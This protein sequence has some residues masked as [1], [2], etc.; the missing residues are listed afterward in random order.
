MDSLPIITRQTLLDSILSQYSVQ[1]GADFAGYRNHCYRVLNVYLQLAQLNHSDVDE[2]EAAV[3]LAFHDIGLWTD[4]TLD[5]LPPSGLEAEQ[6][7]ANCPEL[8]AQQI[9]LMISEHHKLSPYPVNR[10]IELFRQADLVDFSLGLVRHGVSQAFIRKLKAEFPNAGFHRRLLQL[11]LKNLL[12]HPL[13]P[14]PM[15]KW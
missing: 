1:L 14:A 12:R 8:D 2:N 3:A 6:Y 7:L 15:M 13:S 5:Y 4:K 11:G 10:R 9:L